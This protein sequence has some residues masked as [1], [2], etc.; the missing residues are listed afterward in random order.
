MKRYGFPPSP[1]TWKVRAVA[2]YL[3][4]PLEL[5]LVDLGKGA[6]R[7]PAYLAINPTGRTPTLVDGELEK[8][9]DSRE[10]AFGFY[11]QLNAYLVSQLL[12]PDCRLNR[13]TARRIVE[14]FL[15]GAASKK[16]GN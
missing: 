1:N 14:L 2:A 6:Q 9:F 15:A 16:R 12:M 3:K 7:A 13:D 8:R 10:L 5:E 11:G 4:L